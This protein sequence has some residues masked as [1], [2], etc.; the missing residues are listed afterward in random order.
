MIRVFTFA[1]YTSVPLAQDGMSFYKARSAACHD[2]PVGRVPALSALRAMTPT[3]NL[4]CSRR[5]RNGDASCRVD[6]A[7][8]DN[9][10]VYLA[11]A[12][13]PRG[14]ASANLCKENDADSLR[15][16]SGPAWS[17]WGVDSENTRF[18]TSDAA[19]LAT[20]QVPKLKL[21]WAFG[22]GKGGAPGLNRRLRL[23]EFLLETMAERCIR[24]M[25]SRAVLT[26]FF[27]P[28]R[29]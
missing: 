7:G 22:L 6:R 1:F 25:R 27:E 12:E 26:G 2:A 5:R 17:K 28:T 24:W 16:S 18:Q 23:A 13:S 9:V 29:R 14:D 19:G 21:R 11:H 8:A 15:T 10:A 4:K 3:G 20:S